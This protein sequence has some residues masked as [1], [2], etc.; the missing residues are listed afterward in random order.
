MR[1]GGVRLGGVSKNGIIAVEIYDAGRSMK[2][3]KDYLGNEHEIASCLGC[4][5]AGSRIIAPGGVIYEDE[6]FVLSGDPEIAI[7]GFLVINAKRH[8]NSL[9]ELA[10][11]E[12]ANLIELIT[13]AANIVKELGFADQVTILQEERSPHFH[14]WIFPTQDWMREKY[15]EG[16]AYI[17]EICE[18]VREEA[19]TE[20]R[21]EVA[22]SIA[23]IKE[24]FRSEDAG[25]YAKI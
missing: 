14:V 8:V 10:K 13:K 16:A 25:I 7:K 2:K 12:R 1:F 4:E 21:Q 19:T 17:R 5:I 24:R 11:N 9:V 18:N 6:S 22:G 20:E 23:K 15:G 3:I